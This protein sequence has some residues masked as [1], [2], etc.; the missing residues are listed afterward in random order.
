MTYLS[1]T[2]TA[3]T[4]ICV[5]KLRQRTANS[6]LPKKSPSVFM[7]TM[8]TLR[9]SCFCVSPLVACSH[10]GRNYERQVITY[11]HQYLTRTDE[12]VDLMPEEIEE[13]M[14]NYPP[15]VDS[16]VDTHRCI[17]AY[18]E[19]FGAEKIGLFFY[20]DMVSDADRFYKSVLQF[21]ELEDSIISLPT[22]DRL[23]ERRSPI[24]MS[25]WYIKSR[26][27]IPSSLQRLIP[28]SLKSTVS[29]IAESGTERIPQMEQG[30]IEKVRAELAEESA[31][32]LRISGKT[33]NFWDEDDCC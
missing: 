12:R 32:I 27:L 17:G 6:F 33:K 1:T 5:A 16:Y 29:K 21:L 26:R 3:L 24:A 30:L 20:E 4:R 9:S 14:F 8:R 11:K 25:K 7:N 13:A 22:N 23:N 10:L 18:E 19:V 31:S 2:Q 15:L 28:A